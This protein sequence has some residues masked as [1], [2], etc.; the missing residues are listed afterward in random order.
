MRP[1]NSI[2]LFVYGTLKRGAKNHLA[3]MGDMY[4]RETATSPDYILVDLGPYPG[5]IEKLADGF[6]IQGELFEI[7]SSLL[8]NLD[9]IEG[10]PNLFKIEPITLADGSKAFA[11]LYNQSIHGAKI[12]HEGIWT[13]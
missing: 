5:M 11:Y 1:C 3:I 13:S 6:S 8:K 9:K 10:S 12:L 7:P 2:L 4:L